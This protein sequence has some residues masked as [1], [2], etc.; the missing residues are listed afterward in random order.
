MEGFVSFS[1]QGFSKTD[2]AT[3]EDTT[4]MRKGETPFL[5][6]PPIPMKSQGIR[7]R[8]GIFCTSFSQAGRTD[9]GTLQ[10]EAQSIVETSAVPFSASLDLSA[11]P[12]PQ[13]VPSSQQGE[14]DD[15]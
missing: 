7:K 4:S 13:A 5:H 2:T 8:R 9:A 12:C 11:L 10:G 15:I 14:Q 3:W 6:K 1:S